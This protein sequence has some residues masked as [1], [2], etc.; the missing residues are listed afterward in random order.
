MMSL[1]AGQDDEIFPGI[2]FQYQSL[3]GR[4]AYAR[5]RARVA[6]GAF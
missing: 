4:T 2:A 1:K 6:S 3:Q 5:G